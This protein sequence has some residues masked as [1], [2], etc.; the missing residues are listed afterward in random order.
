VRRG[1]CGSLAIAWREG[2]GK[3]GLF[4]EDQRISVVTR[5][6]TAKQHP[7]NIRPTFKNRTQK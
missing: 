1:R 6:S 7:K 2:F 4:D 5:K 3:I